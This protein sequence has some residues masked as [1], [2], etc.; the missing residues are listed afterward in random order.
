MCIRDSY[1]TD[2]E[3]P[4]FARLAEAVGIHGR[5]VERPDDLPSAIDDLL[6]HDGPALLDVTT[7]RQ[8]L[9]IPPTV[10]AA[11]AKGFTLYTLRTVLSGR[12]D[13][14]IDLAETNVFR[15]LFD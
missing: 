9:S 1:G 11:Q 14:I 10:T 8:E 4:D 13:E 2:L 6:A 15:R 5:R 12:G 7:A 3:N